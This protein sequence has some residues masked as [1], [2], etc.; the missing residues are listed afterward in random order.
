MYQLGLYEKS[1]PNSL[2][3]REKLAVTRRCGYDHL[4][5]SIDES[6]EKLSRLDWDEQTIASLQADMRAEGV[7]IRSIC[8]SGHRKYPL[9]HPDPAV[10][11]R[12]LEILRKAVHLAARLGIRI[13]QLAGYDVYY[14]Q[15]TAETAAIFEKN[16]RRSV[17]IAAEQGVVLAFETMETE[18][19]NTVEKA[20]CW[21]DRIS[22]PYLQV[23]PDAGNITNA[24][25]GES[26]KVADDLRS[27]RGHLAAVH[28]KESRPGVYR[29]VPYGQGHVDFETVTRTAME[30]GVRLYLAEFW[31]VGQ[32]DWEKTIA[33]N[34]VFLRWYL[35]RAANPGGWA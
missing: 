18:F 19:L 33:D 10:Q 23:Y 3:L 6:D 17:E 20:M 15:G 32:E 26:K 4:E 13:I 29:E 11:A 27:G 22:S 21:V 28:L 2:S 5:L 25:R 12:S 9:G 34:G 7:P 30:L 14:E 35:N 24:A 31:Y 16:L 1:M 8:L